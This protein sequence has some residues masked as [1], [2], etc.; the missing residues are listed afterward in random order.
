MREVDVLVVWQLDR[1]GRSSPHLVKTVR[2]LSDRCIG[3]H[4]LSEQCA[5]TD[6]TTSAGTK[7][8]GIFATLAEF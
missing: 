8:F 3:M 7:T 5:E 4:V 6:T 2:D 1:L